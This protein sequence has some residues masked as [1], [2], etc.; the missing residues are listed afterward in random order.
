MTT[1]DDYFAALTD[2]A[3][4]VLGAPM[5]DGTVVVPAQGRA[6]SKS[7]T[8]YPT[9][10]GTIVWCDPDLVG[11]L[12]GIH[13]EGA[14]SSV[15]F[16][17]W[18]LA[19][20]ASLVGF[21]NNRVLVDSLRRPQAD[22]EGLVVRRLD[23]D[24][25]DDRSKLAALVDASSE[26]DVDEADLDLDDLDPFIVGLL[27][28]DGVIA[29]YAAARPSEIDDTFEDIA[30]LTRPSFRRRGLGAAAVFEFVSA[31]TVDD[32][33]RRFLYRCTTENAGSNALAESLG[34]T[35]AHTIG[36]VRFPE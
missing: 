32:P 19:S 2:D 36:A 17:E 16:V 20:G 4:S 11:V 15:E 27:T 6:G 25:V 23:P 7:A 26:D 31:R 10:S 21:G 22:V 14:I 35:M 13:T 12:A 33:T 24:D 28:A 5:R 29:A 34:F 18:A 3:E 30:V 9:P 8:S 1:L